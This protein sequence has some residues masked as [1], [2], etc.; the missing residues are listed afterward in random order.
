[1]NIEDV[2]KN[3]KVLIDGIPFNIE[4][5]EFMKPGKGSAVYRLRL[6]NLVDG[7]NVNR[8]YHSGDKL[9][10]ISLDAKKEQFLYKQE[11]QYVFMDSETYEQHSIPEQL[12]G[13]KS[14]FLKEG[15]P[16]TVTFMGER[17]LDVAMP[18]F[19]ELIIT[20]TAATTRGDTITAQNKPALLETGH[21]IN[22]PTF[23]KEGDVIKVDTRSGA[24]V[25]RVTTKK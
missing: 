21:T 20:G 10:E 13:E 6:R 22:V 9:E 8:T 1:M 25:E 12:L 16:V 4:E 2:R 7:S 11:D 24:Y 14:H 3:V 17:P 19:V 18:N 23:V 5:N 15:M